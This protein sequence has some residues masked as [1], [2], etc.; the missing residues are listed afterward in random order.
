LTNDDSGLSFPV[1]R[2]PGFATLS[3]KELLKV[4]GPDEM[5]PVGLF[6]RLDQTPEDMSNCGEYRIVYAKN[7]PSG[8]NRFF[9]IFEAVLPNP[10][11]NSNVEG[12]RQVAKFW[13]G[14]RSAPDDKIAPALNDFYYNGGP[15]AGG[16]LKF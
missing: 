1:I 11:P 8:F 16:S 2:Q 12:C 3:A 5:L 15:L 9:L 13:D 7:N 10:D 6:N 14:F 4:D